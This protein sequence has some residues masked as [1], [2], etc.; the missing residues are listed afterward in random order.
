MNSKFANALVAAATV[1]YGAAVSLSQSTYYEL[2]AGMADYTLFTGVGD[3]NH[4]NL[5]SDD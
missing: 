4:I 3:A 1:Q 5:N 2:G